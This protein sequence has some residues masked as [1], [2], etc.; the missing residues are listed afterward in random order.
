MGHTKINYWWTDL[1]NK[2]HRSNYMK[3]K[4]VKENESINKNKTENEIMKKRGFYKI[5][6]TG[7]IKF[8]YIN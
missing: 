4:I 1:I 8:E 7:N 3:Y 6:G 5:Y 2:Y